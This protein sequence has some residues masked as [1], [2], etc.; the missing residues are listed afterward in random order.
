MIAD[1][2]KHFLAGFCAGGT[3]YWLTSTI[4]SALFSDLP[5]GLPKWAY[6]VVAYGIRICSLLLAVSLA[7]VSHWALDYWLLF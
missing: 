5:P 2:L 7:L 1:S 4:L 6:T 3:L